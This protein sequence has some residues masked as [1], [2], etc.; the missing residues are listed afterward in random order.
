MLIKN[1]NHQ[2]MNLTFEITSKIKEFGARKC[3]NE[4]EFDY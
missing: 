3:T 1:F 4:K 2:K